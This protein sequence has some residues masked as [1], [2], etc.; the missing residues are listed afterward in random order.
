MLCLRFAR[1]AGMRALLAGLWALFL[2]GCAGLSPSPVHDAALTRDA[3]E[4]FTLEARFALRH[5]A[6]SYSGLLSWRHLPARDEM[7]LA[8][9]LGQGLA[10]IISDADGARLKGSDGK[11]HLAA[12]VAALTEPLLG[13]PLPLERLSAW[14]R[15]RGSDAGRVQADAGGRPSTLAED[16]WLITYTYA[17][18]NPQALPASLLVERQNVLELRLRID[19]W[20]AW[21]AAPGAT[22]GA[23]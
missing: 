2:G 20:S 13:F 8:S 18:D 9:P 22:H 3:L 6:R 21:N 10:E 12:D 15:G 23:D 14:V 11:L 4:F 17:D 1:A 7:L 5:D 16:G 19:D